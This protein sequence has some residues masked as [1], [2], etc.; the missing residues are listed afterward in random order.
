MG[1][2]KQQSG[3]E[4]RGRLESNF[5]KKKRRKKERERLCVEEMDKVFL[6]RSKN[7]SDSFFV[8]LC[9]VLICLSLS[10]IQ[11]VELVSVDFM[12]ED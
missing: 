4:V 6:L 10:V 2:T 1:Q 11:L 8:L 5:A 3:G 12:N 7:D 9:S